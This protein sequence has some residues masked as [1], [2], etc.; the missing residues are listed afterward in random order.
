[1]VRHPREKRGS[2]A[3]ARVSAPLDSQQAEIK[4]DTFSFTKYGL[5]HGTVFN[6]SA[7]SIDRNK[8]PADPANTAKPNTDSASEPQ[9][10]ELVYAAHVSLERTAMAIDGKDVRSPPEWR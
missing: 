7:D 10:H 3:A 4:V 1:V 9:G 8:P 6:V 5:L 2:R